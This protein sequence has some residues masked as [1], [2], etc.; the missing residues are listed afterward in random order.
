MMG[1][2]QELADCGL[3][4]GVIHEEGQFSLSI[5]QQLLSLLFFAP[6]C[7]VL[8]RSMLHWQESTDVFGSTTLVVFI[9]VMNCTFDST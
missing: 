3:M 5:L 8:C 1:L 4:V 9:T 7:T 6:S 2:W